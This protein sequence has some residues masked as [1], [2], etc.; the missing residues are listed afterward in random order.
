MEIELADAVATLRDELI[1]AA[2]RSADSHVAF[3]VGPIE[4]EFAVELKKDAKVKAGFKAWVVSGD[5]E[6]GVVRGRTHRIKVAL[7]PRTAD[8]TDVL[9]HGTGERQG[10]SDEAEDRIDG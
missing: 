7:T 1:A 9:I 10:G 3:V 6:V 4:M 2:G 5:T 8:G